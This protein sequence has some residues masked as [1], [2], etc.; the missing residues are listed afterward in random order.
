MNDKFVMNYAGRD[1][2]YDLSAGPAEMTN[3][4]D[5][6]ARADLLQAL[7]SCT[8]ANTRKYKDQPGP[9]SVHFFTRPL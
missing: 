1:K 6:P 2:L 7:R 3:L 5:D 8:L 9:Q 4:I